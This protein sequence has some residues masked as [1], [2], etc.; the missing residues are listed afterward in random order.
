MLFWRLREGKTLTDENYVR[1]YLEIL[2]G[3]DSYEN[4]R[5][6][7]SPPPPLSRHRVTA[8]TSNIFAKK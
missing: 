4:P 1:C 7:R 3:E 2:P 6:S 8:K 5:E